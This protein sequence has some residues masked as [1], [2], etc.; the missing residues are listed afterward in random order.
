MS[1][2]LPERREFETLDSWQLRIEDALKENFQP[3]SD[4]LE[5]LQNR[6]NEMEERFESMKSLF[7]SLGNLGGLS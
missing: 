2:K 5:Y 6:L 3:I 7:E 1:F 4:K